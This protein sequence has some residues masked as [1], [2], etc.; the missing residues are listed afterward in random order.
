MVEVDG[1]VHDVAEF[2]EDL[3]FVVSVAASEDQSRSAAH[4]ATIFIGPLDD[5]DVP[6]A[7]HPVR[8]EGP[9]PFRRI[10]ASSRA[11]AG[12]AARGG[13]AF[14]GV[15]LDGMDIVVELLGDLLANLVDLVEDRVSKRGLRGHHSPSLAACK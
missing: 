12:G 8:G 9:G 3:L 7:L 2:G 4:V 15:F 5:F 11:L 1:L 14:P 10:L 6:P 13:L